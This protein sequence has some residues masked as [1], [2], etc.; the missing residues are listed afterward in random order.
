M[1]L[2]VVI[3]SFNV[4][5]FLDQAIAT[6]SDA[7][8]SLDVEV[9]VV[10]NASTDG[11]PDMVKRKYPWVS[12]IES[13]VNLGFAKANNLAL[14]RVK[15]R[16]ILL[17]NPD[18]V[19]RT[20][21]LTTMVSFLHAHPGTGAAGCKVIN[22]DGSLQ[23]ACRRGFPTPGV[24]FYKMIG[25]SGLFPKSRTFG[26]YNL[27]YLDA[28]SLSEV[29]AV[30]GSFMM[31]RKEALDRIGYLDEKFFM[32][33]EDLD[34]CY[35]IKEDGWKIHY[36]PDTEI[37]HFKGESARSVPTL[38]SVRDFYTA[39]RIFVEKHYRKDGSRN[40]FPQWLI[41]AAIY[42]SMGLVSG[43]RMI[44]RA[45]QPLLDLFLLN[46]SL[47]MGILLRFGIRLENAPDYSPLQWSSIFIV[48]S[49]LYM[50]T[51]F[52]M[53]LY[54]RFRNVPERSLLGIFIGFLFNVF[55]VNFIKQY[56]FSRIASFYCWG[57]NSIFISGWR[58]VYQLLLAKKD[59]LFQR[60]AVVVGKIDNAVK[61]KRIF[62]NAG[63][64]YEII[65]CVET[66]HDA[67]RGRETDGLHVLGLVNDLEDV[68]KEYSV[69]TVIMVG[70]T[71]P[72]SR[73]L[74][75]GGRFGL[76]QPEFKLVPE[77]KS[78]E[79]VKDM[80]ASD[81]TLIDIN[82]GSTAGKKRSK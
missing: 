35:R 69:D 56:N 45:W 22:P 20:D 79:K 50:A 2:S 77:L 17:L 66:A 80:K 57:F 82:P 11:S 49:A 39:M 15:G 23:L 40:I 16:Y 60:Q 6:L 70:S 21:T 78:L 61:L 48:Y 54:H 43:V 5:S 37:I 9:F 38:K 46:V 10:D 81:I 19:L 33:G 1:D 18:T 53:G 3:V 52:F 72:Y 74:G 12:L 42:L 75:T 68:I 41:I 47:V 26:A 34:L 4:S 31:L 59:R 58:F 62:G 51:F 64:P 44:K 32:Y 67:I 73:I 76:Y 30:S 36:V 55:I 7:I 29:D 27:T 24:A 8:G 65:G 71:I 14:S 28:D 13:E 63:V 25:L